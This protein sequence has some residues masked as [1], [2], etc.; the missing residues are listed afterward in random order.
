MSSVGLVLVGRKIERIFLTNKNKGD[1]LMKNVVKIIPIMLFLLAFGCETWQVYAPDEDGI[2]AVTLANVNVQFMVDDDLIA[3]QNE[4]WNGA[5]VTVSKRIAAG[6]WTEGFDRTVLGRKIS[7]ATAFFD[8][9]DEIKLRVR[10]A[11]DDILRID[12]FKIGE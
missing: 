12:Y 6:E 5:K 4:N 1:G 9:G 2:F 8:R 3:V 10:I 7:E 11:A